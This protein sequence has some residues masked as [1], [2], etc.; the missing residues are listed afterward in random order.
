[1]DQRDVARIVRRGA[2]Y[3]AE[4]L[5]EYWPASGNNDIP[6]RNVS[7]HLARA[8]AERGFL[9]YGEANPRDRTDARLD[10]LA[11]HESRD[12]L[13]MVESKRLYEPE[14]VEAMLGDAE[15]IRT[16]RPQEHED[17]RVGK[18]ARFGVLAA[19]TWSDEAAAW[20]A[21]TDE[22]TWPAGQARWAGFLEKRPE[23]SRVLETALFG[24][25]VVQGYDGQASTD[26]F[27]YVL[28]C[29]FRANPGS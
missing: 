2:L 8:F 20:W 7:L 15:R 28:Y 11:L 27:H 6:E 25:V 16:F 1:M 24:S 14:H 21:A 19:T 9:C 4:S 3:L 22:S 10:L 12:V 17:D 5:W 29:V 13:A 23:L 26:P 18:A